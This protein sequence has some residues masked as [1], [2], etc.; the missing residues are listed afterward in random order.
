MSDFT[1]LVLADGKGTRF[2]MEKQFFNWRGKALWEHVYNT[3][4]DL[5]PDRVVVGIDIAGGTTRQASV[6]SGLRLVDTP[7][8]VILE[9]CAPLVRKEHIE[10][11][12]K[13]DA[14][15]V[16]YRLPS[17]DLGYWF[18]DTRTFHT[19]QELYPLACP[20]MFDTERL[21]Q[22]HKKTTFT[23][24]PDDTILMKEVFGL[25]PYLLPAKYPHCLQKVIFPEDIAII[26]ALSL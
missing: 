10:A 2:G 23:D 26:D 13:V 20:Q 5:T 19:P 14:S 24:A 22:A 17:N 16:S 1:C 4:V 11:L 21:K 15:S 25:E 18:Q 12:L 9:A 6:K 8:V 7:R 3:I